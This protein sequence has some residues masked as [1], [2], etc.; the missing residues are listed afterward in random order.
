MAATATHSA[1]DVAG[2]LGDFR[3]F[4]SLINIRVKAGNRLVPFHYDD[5]YDEQKQFNR[6]RTGRDVSLKPRQIGFTT[7]ELARDLWFA[8]TR[9][10]VNVQI[11]V[12]DKDLARQL[13]EAMLIFKDTLDE[14]G[15]F[16]ETRYS[17]EKEFVFKKSGSAV[18][19][20]EA[21]A[22]ERAA[23]KKGRSGTIHRLHMT[24]MAF[25][26]AAYDTV[27]GVMPSAELAQEIVIESTANGQGGL[28]YEQ[29][30]A[31]Q[32]GTSGYKLHFF[33][34][35]EHKGYERDVPA[36]FDDAPADD[37]ERAMRRLGVTDRQIQWWRT[38]DT[39]VNLGLD[40]MLQDYPYSIET[41]FRSAGDE[42]MDEPT[43]LHLSHSVR[44]PIRRAP[45]TWKGK[46]YGEALIYQNPRPGRQYVIGG[47]IAEG[48]GVEKDFSACVVLDRKT[49]RM[50]AVFASNK[51]E[52]GDFAYVMAV[53]GYQF[54]SAQLGPERNNHGHT[55]L[56][57]LR[58][59]LKYPNIYRARNQK[60]KAVKWG[61]ETNLATRPPLFD[62]I[63]TA[64]RT[65]AYDCPDA[66]TCSEA[67]T[68]IRGPSG[69]PVARDKGRKGG[70]HDDRFVAWAIAHQMRSVPEWKGGTFNHPGA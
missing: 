37:H 64:C 62:D 49:G 58:S 59:E 39:R 21:G 52:P 70:A 38:N 12:H 15:L 69:R 40:R 41:C 68:L 23:S 53:L 27:G 36:D 57:V 14:V 63:Y 35:F 50:C 25:W 47:D 46:F 4:C 48:E 1:D 65:K 3:V 11:I 9:K 24:E 56:R 66:Q 34:W 16:P 2:V 30:M 29:V 33:R 44:E 31:A 5:W 67:R 19:I 10:G 55:V 28:F 60:D 13:W 32:A 8:M 7:E 22:T 20:V 6:D 17:T 42:F 18:R 43:R 26:S 54:N 51:M 61:W 45:I